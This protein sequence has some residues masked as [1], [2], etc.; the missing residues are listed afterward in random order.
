M[1]KRKN[2]APTFFF[3]ASAFFIFVPALASASATINVNLPGASSATSPGGWVESFYQFALMIAGVL[4]F[5]VIIYGGIRY[6][7]SVGNPS[8]EEEAKQWI[9]AALTGVLLL[10]GAYIILNVI[11]PQLLNLTLPKLSAISTTASVASP[12]TAAPSTSAC[13]APNTGNCTVA[14]L[15]QTCLSSVATQFAGICGH[16]SGGA[17]T[18][19]SGSDYC[20]PASG[21]SCPGGKCTASVGLFQVNLTNS[22]KQ[23]V[24]GQ[25]CSAAFVNG[26]TGAGQAVHCSGKSPCT[27]SSGQACQ[28]SNVQLYNDCVAAA[29][30]AAANISVTCQLSNNGSNL[31][32]WKAD[33]KAC[34][35]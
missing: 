33:A 11:N 16:E 34:G 17:A 35:F 12:S 10:A 1:L 22:W 30:N 21:Q 18:I 13:A 14:S 15:Q 6:M 8:G 5:G 24:D 29:Q 20:N 23:T 32:P 2:F 19:K 7:T 26:S 25:N 4:A 9:W 28:V 27:G 3:L 31:G